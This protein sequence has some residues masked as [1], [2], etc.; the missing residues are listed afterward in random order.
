MCIRDSCNVDTMSDL[1]EIEK[2]FNDGMIAIR[3]LEREITMYKAYFSDNE[4]FVVQV[5][6]DIVSQY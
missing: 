3:K 1:H 6:N 4:K 2:V 5:V